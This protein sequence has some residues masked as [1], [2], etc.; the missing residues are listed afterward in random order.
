MDKENETKLPPE[1]TKS[2]QRYFN[3]VTVASFKDFLPQLTQLFSSYPLAEIQST[4]IS[5]IIQRITRIQLQPPMVALYAGALCALHKSFPGSELLVAGNILETVCT[6]LQPYLSNDRGDIVDD[7][8]S[9]PPQQLCILLGCL[10]SYGITTHTIVCDVMKLLIHPSISSDSKIN[11][12]LPIA[13]RPLHCMMLLNLLQSS[14]WKLYQ[15]DI[16]DV[17]ISFVESYSKKGLLSLNS[18][19]NTAS[20][21]VMNT[22]SESNGNASELLTDI[23]FLPSLAHLSNNNL[24]SSSSIESTS[25]GAS[26]DSALRGRMIAETLNAI[27]SP[28]ATDGISE[29]YTSHSA[30]LP[31]PTASSSSLT[32]SAANKQKRRVARQRHAALATGVAAELSNVTTTV[33]SSLGFASHDELDAS[34]KG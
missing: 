3:Q 33:L 14:W 19:P 34:G 12:E 11:E 25:V 20:A 1:A 17:A 23:N 29:G 21:Q 2:L 7:T 10:Y 32:A 5:L 13:S 18:N 6:L 30:L 9:F 16:Y 28:L 31:T 8:A 27:L 24:S 26:G 22:S 15:E 4:M